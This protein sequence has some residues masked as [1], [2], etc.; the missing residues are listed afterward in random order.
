MDVSLSRF[1]FLPLVLAAMAPGGASATD[2]LPRDVSQLIVSIAPDWDATHGQLARLEREADGTWRVASSAITVVYGRNG[3]A[4]GR[5]VLGTDKPGRHKQ[6]GDG[7]TPAGVFAVGT[8]YGYASTLPDGADFPYHQVTTA[9]AWIEDPALPDYNRHVVV[10]PQNP[11]P[12]FKR[13]HM[14]LDDSAYRWLVEIRH[15]A[16]PPV[17][18]AGS[19]I[20][21]HVRRGPGRLTAGCTALPEDDLVDLI[22]WLRVAAHPHYV[23]LPWDEYERLAADWDLPPV[24]F[25]YLLKPR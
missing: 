7:C 9:D 20:F 2:A 15:N 17:P 24:E 21:L 6:E 25:V 19:A 3:L 4:W 16:D 22:R 5:G 14:R 11:P 18:G 8:V 23:L 13:E 10:D 1:R 12:W